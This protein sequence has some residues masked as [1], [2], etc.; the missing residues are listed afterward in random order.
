MVRMEIYLDITLMEGP[1]P[2]LTCDIKPAYLKYY[3]KLPKQANGN[4]DNT[5]TKFSNQELSI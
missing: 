4:F 1:V 3:F 2:L 5:L